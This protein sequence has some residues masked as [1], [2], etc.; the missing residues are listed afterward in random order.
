MT[1]NKKFLITKAILNIISG[2]SLVTIISLGVAYMSF[3][4]AFV[5][6][7]INIEVTNN[8]VGKERDI[9]FMM[10]G[11]KK[12]ECNSTKVYGVAYARDGSASH[13]LD[14]FSKSYTRNVSPGQLMPNQWN[15]KVPSEMEGG[16]IYRVSMTG[17]FVCNY[18]IFQTEKSQ[19]F[20]NIYLKITPR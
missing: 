19:T 3:T 4:N 7:D 16:G 14:L 13:S 2:I 6:Q 17:E 11:S 15:M 8:P 18:L 10:I 1:P 12:H 9:E 20:D 5:F